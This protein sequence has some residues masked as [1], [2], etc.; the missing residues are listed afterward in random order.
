MTFIR[1][2]QFASAGCNIRR[3]VWN[4]GIPFSLFLNQ[5]RMLQWQSPNIAGEARLCPPDYNPQGADLGPEDINAT[6][7]EVLQ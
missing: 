7:W 6:D 4:E 3:A 2:I 5:D 1:A